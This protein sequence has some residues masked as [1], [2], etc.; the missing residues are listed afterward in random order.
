MTTKL[1]LG[2]LVTVGFAGIPG[3][4]QAAVAEVAC[5]EMAFSQAVETHDGNA[6]RALLDEDARFI[7]SGVLRGADEVSVAWGG[8]LDPAAPDLVWRPETIEILQSGDLAFSRGP[9]RLRGND[10]QAAESWGMYNSLWRR[11]PDGIWKVLFDAGTPA[12]D[13]KV[14]DASLSLLL[15]MPVPAVCRDLDSAGID[16]S[17]TIAAS[18]ESVWKAWTDSDAA[19]FVAGESNIELRPGGPFEWFLQQEPDRQGKRG[20]EGSHV[21]S[22]VPQRMLVFAWTYPPD[23]P[24]LRQKG[25]LMHVLVEFDDRAG[26]AVD[27]RLRVYGFGDGDDYEK[28]RSYFEAA[29]TYVLNAMKSHLEAQ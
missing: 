29:W 5:A 8:L 25:E 27:V 16:K 23:V 9:Y 15:E 17:L 18:L 26:D 1:G 7:S 21:L 11:Q 2:L 24:A 10:E 13:G 28:G 19:A 4:V 6:F 20:S 14:I 12:A 22:W 3:G